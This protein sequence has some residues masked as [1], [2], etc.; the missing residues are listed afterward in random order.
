[1]LAI[2]GSARI[3]LCHEPID[4]RKGFQGLSTIVIDQLKEDL[5]SNS[6]FVFLNRG[7]D[8]IKILY[9]DGDGL[10]IWQKRLEKGRFAKQKEE[11]PLMQRREFL[12]VLEGIV[13]KRVHKRYKLS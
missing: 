1:M 7:R 13:P 2:N 10:A 4:L 8:R 6:Y 9:F 5:V 12:M 11:R 3:F